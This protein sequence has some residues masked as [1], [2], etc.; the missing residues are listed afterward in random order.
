MVGRERLAVGL[1][2]DQR[3]LVLERLERHIRREALLGVR[4]DEASARVRL[5]ELRELAPVDAAEA[6]V[7]AAPARDAVD[8]DLDLGRSAARGARPSRA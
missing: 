2:G 7:E 4:D 1:V 6:G 8:V 5:D 3:L